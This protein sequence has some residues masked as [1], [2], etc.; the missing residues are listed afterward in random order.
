MRYL[1]NTVYACCFILLQYISICP[2][3]MLILVFIMICYYLGIDVNSLWV[4]QLK[5]LLSLFRIGII[6]F[7]FWTF[8]ICLDCNTYTMIVDRFTLF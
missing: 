3:N 6:A 5:L 4:Y 8:G 1:L 2:W 7:P